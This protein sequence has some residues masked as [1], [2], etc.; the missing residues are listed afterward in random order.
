MLKKLILLFVALIAFLA[1][2]GPARAF[3]APVVLY[4]DTAYVGTEEGTQDKPYNTIVEANAFAQNKPG[5]GVI[6]VKK[7]GVY[8]YDHFVDPVK[9]GPTGIPLA[10]P[11]LFGI[12][13][14]ISLLLILAGLVLKRRS[15]ALSS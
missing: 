9:A 11:V 12:L 6:M 7:D 10:G 2:S 15:K 14:V 1:G 8:V 5:G 3:V 13:A 4:V